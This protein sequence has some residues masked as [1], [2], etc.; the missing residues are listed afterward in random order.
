MK[1]ETKKEHKKFEDEKTE[2]DF[3]IGKLGLG[4]LFKGIEKLVDLAERVEQA[5]GEIKKSGTIKGLGGRD[6]VRGVYGFTIRTGL[7]QKTRVEPF[8]NIKKTKTGPRVSET[9]EPIIDVFDEKNHVLVIVELPGIDEKSIK[10]DLKKPARPAGGDI[11]LLEAESKER[12][13]VKEILLPAQIDL[14]SREMSFKN[15]LLE[16]K[17]KKTA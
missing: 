13:Y 7:G 2:I 10:I 8:G 12:K 1:K 3:D 17:F 9:R 11:L 5:G 4:G 15:G 16:L 6:D 14:E